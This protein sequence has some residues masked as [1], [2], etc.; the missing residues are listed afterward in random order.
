MAGEMAMPPD[1]VIESDRPLV[2]SLPLPP[3]L[4]QVWS[5]ASGPMKTSVAVIVVS[6]ARRTLP[7]R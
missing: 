5:C 3:G 1:A 7:S 2:Q 4:K 6:P